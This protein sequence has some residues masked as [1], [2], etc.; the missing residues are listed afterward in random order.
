LKE[1]QWKKRAGSSTSLNSRQQRKE[2]ARKGKKSRDE[3]RSRLTRRRGNGK[4]IKRGKGQ[5][6]PA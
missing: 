3:E 6:S 5:G 4:V 1:R 2:K